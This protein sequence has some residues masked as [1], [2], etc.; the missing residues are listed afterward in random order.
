M[1]KRKIS[2]FHRRTKNVTTDVTYQ[3]RGLQ[4]TECI[5]KNHEVNSHRVR[6]F[7][8]TQSHLGVNA[9]PSGVD[10]VW[11]SDI[12]DET[13]FWLFNETMKSRSEY[14]SRG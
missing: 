9:K 13:T 1:T 8:T 10:F 6:W 4:R 5:Q 11:R 12:I 3:L 7:T 14:L 2:S